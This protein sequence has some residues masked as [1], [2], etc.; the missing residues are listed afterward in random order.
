M[1]SWMFKKTFYETIFIILLS[2]A[3]S[4]TVNHIWPNIIQ[5]SDKNNINDTDESTAQEIS[6]ETAK[7]LIDEKAAILIDSRSKNEFFQDYI[8]GALN[9]PEQE[10]DECIDNFLSKTDP[11]T[12]IITY[13]DG[14]QCDLAKN[15]AEKLKL[16]GFSHVFYIKNG[17]SRW[18]EKYGR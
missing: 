11:E 5:P 9:L 18:K 15:L 13:C 12:I 1:N 8:K 7:K 17:W 14:S 4:F 16:I 6:I 10:F 3:V 2:V